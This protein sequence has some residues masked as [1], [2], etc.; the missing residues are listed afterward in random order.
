MYAK[1]AAT[2]IG[3]FCRE[4]FD[5][6]PDRMQS[7][8]ANGEMIDVFDHVGYGTHKYIPAD[9]L[10]EEL[11]MRVGGG[12]YGYWKMKDGSY[13]LRTCPGPL[14]YWSGSDDDKA[15]WVTPRTEKVV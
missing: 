15:E 10:T 1:I 12:V 11:G 4:T 9:R 13:L 6:D 8:M 2:Y 5:K 14:A 7:T 3:A